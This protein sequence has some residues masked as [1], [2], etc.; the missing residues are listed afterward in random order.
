MH[1]LLLELLYLIRNADF[2]YANWVFFGTSQQPKG[3]LDPCKKEKLFQLPPQ[4]QIDLSEVREF[5]KRQ[6]EVAKVVKN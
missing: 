6:L 1:H 2:Q 3:D 5:L 4:Q